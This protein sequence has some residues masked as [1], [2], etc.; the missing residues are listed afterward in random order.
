MNYPISYH[1]ACAHLVAF[2]GHNYPTRGR[3]IIARA[4]W[5]LRR[6]FGRQYARDTWRG[7][8]FIAGHFPIKKEVQS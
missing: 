2:G 8:L 6:R 4:L 7:M 1:Q 5:D 3:K